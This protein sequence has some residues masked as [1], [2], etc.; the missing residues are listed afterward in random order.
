MVRCPELS[1]PVV[2]AA[3][4]AHL[5]QS[6][7]IAEESGD[8]YARAVLAAAT[9]HQAGVFAV[10]HGPGLGA[11][12]AVDPATFAGDVVGFITY[13]WRAALA[14]TLLLPPP[15]PAVDTVS[16]NRFAL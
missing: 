7:R 3:T 16:L 6:E 8:A 13:Y 2:N 14:G 11:A 9:A 10:R 4:V 12:G 5:R 15:D 1:H